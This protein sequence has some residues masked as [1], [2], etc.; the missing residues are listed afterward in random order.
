[1]GAAPP[2]DDGDHAEGVDFA[3]V[4]P[5]R[6][7]CS[8]AWLQQAIGRAAHS[9]RSEGLL[10]VLVSPRWRVIADRLMRRTGLEPRGGLLTVPPG[11]HCMHVV[12]LHSAALR[13][14]SARHL[15]L[16]PAVAGC[17][18]ALARSRP[19]RALARSAAPGCALIAVRAPAADPLRW[20]AALGG[21]CA[22]CA[23][24]AATGPR[25][26][27]PVA[28]VLRFARTGRRAPDLV[29]KVALGAAGCER[30]E[31]ESAALAGLGDSARRAGVVVPVVLSDAPGLLATT[32]LAGPTASAVIARDPARATATMVAASGWLCRWAGATAA[33]V[34]A[35]PQVLHRLLL[36]PAARVEAAGG[37]GHM[38]EYAAALGSLAARL[39][40]CSIVLAPA[41]NDLTMSNIVLL[42]GGAIGIVDWESACAAMPPLVDLWYVL[43]DGVARGGTLTHA[44]AVTA[45]VQ[46]GQAAPAA[47]AGAPDERARE[48]A[49]T[50]DEA[51]LAFHACWLHH[52]C[53]ELDRG[54]RDG[55]FLAVVQAVATARLRWPGSAAGDR[56]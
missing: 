51:L 19:G 34:A 13:D 18:A 15:G 10:C 47:L 12:S 40:G 24:A 41:H 21:D 4:A 54:Q 1:G 6:A 11:P 44:Q 42:D 56:T 16:H 27:S 17:V 55:P 14:A 7:E 2:S 29:A 5:L 8:R 38:S 26:D 45:L 52:A 20:L 39:E 9:L 30:V 23:A 49:L 22:G 35:G 36:E 53:N 3:L 37:G 31:R 50:A 32:A 43:A 33:T 48:L 28:V 46:G 25:A